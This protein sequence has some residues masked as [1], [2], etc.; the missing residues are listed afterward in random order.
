MPALERL[1]FLVGFDKIVQI[2]DPRYY[3]DRED[4]LR[5]LFSVASFAVAPA[6]GPAVRS[7]TS[8]SGEPRTGLSLAGFRR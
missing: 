2:F 5:Q 8:C 4:A 6:G 1:V 7:L 3:D